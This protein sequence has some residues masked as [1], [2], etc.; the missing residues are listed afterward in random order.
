MVV[1]IL[2]R[3][4]CILLLPCWVFIRKYYSIVSTIGRVCHNNYLSSFCFEY[5]INACFGVAAHLKTDDAGL[6][7]PRRDWLNAHISSTPADMLPEHSGKMVLLLSI[8]EESKRLGDRVVVFS[9][10]LHT[11]N[12]V[13]SMLKKYNSDKPASER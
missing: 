3:L 10:W 8:L 9:R 5:F 7:G 12:F 1:I 4:R 11:L 13:E 2:H 6:I